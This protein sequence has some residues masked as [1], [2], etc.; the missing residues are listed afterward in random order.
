MLIGA[1]IGSLRAINYLSHQ[2]MTKAHNKIMMQPMLM[3]RMADCW[4]YVG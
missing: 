3:P 1:A 2:S 4:G